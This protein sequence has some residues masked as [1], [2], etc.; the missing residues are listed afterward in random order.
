[1]ALIARKSVRE[2]KRQTVKVAEECA[3][4]IRCRCPPAYLVASIETKGIG[5]AFRAAYT[6][7][8]EAVGQLDAMQAALEECRI[9]AEEF[10]KRS[11]RIE[12]AEFERFIRE[13]ITRVLE[14]G[15]EGATSPVSPLTNRRMRS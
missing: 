15:A 4:V 12:L 13:T 10:T 7:S 5:R 9:Y 3:E 11:V 8:V 6:A 2:L 14:G 1:M